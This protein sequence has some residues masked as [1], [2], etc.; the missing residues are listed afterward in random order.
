MKKFKKAL[1]FLLT[2]AMLVSVCAGLGA[3]AEGI[4]A[5]ASAD[6]E[7][8][9]ASDA[10]QTVKV[11]VA[12]SQEIQAVS[13]SA[14]ISVPEGWSIAKGADVKT[15]ISNAAGTGNAGSI[16]AGFANNKIAKTFSAAEYG[17]DED[18]YIKI[19]GFT[20]TYTVP[21]EANTGDQEV[22]LKTLKITALDGTNAITADALTTVT[23]KAAQT[24][25]YTVALTA[26]ATADT[27]S[28]ID[29]T[30]DVTSGDES[31]YNAFY[32]TLAYDSSK[33]SY[34]GGASVSGFNVDSSVAGTLKISRSGADVTI[35]DG[36]DLA[37]PFTADD[38]GDAVFTLSAAKVD[39]AAN[40][41]TDAP[42]ATVSGNPVTTVISTP[43][44]TYS[45]TV[46]LGGNMTS[47]GGDLS[48][49]GLTDAM[50]DVVVAPS[51]GY[52][53][54]APTIA[55]A[56]A[57]ISVTANADGS[58]TVS[59]TPT[60]NVTVTFA[61]ATEKTPVVTSE[62]SDYC[63]GYTLIKATIDMTGYVPTYEGTQMY[64]IGDAYYYVVDGKATGIV[65]AVAGTATTLTRSADANGTGVIDIN[66][67]QFVYNVYSG[68]Y[69]TLSVEKLLRADVT[70]DG[71]VNVQDCAAIVAAIA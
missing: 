26:P 52:E 14:E 48:Q 27:E 64:K 2:A 53:L 10:T 8:I 42:K 31:T 18:E 47:S 6:K 33:V 12:L 16:N 49:T 30:L 32:A 37:L 57:G 45:V 61:D 66:D 35:A 62:T 65:S 68:Y 17:A 71:E 11:T 3:L 38:T 4:T 55:P 59:G 13:Y 50:T 39:K 60:A 28:S 44:A 46:A 5:A 36:A 25:G 41:E 56:D 21:A 9:T 1:T 23:V 15:T 19:T 63:D 29:V 70:G 43:V 67:A 7:E 58:Y 69:S 54:A 20:I 24:P 22:G 40:A 51:G 34:A